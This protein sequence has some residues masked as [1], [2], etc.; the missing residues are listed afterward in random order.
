M[1]H[2]PSSDTPY[3]ATIARLWDAV[4]A[5]DAQ[6]LNALFAPDIVVR[7]PIT[8]LVCFEGADQVSDLF[9]RIFAFLNNIRMYEVVGQ[10]TATQ[11]IFWRGKVG[12]TYL[13]EANLIKMNEQGQISEMT[14]F[15]RAIPG[16]LVLLS[17]IAPSLASRHGWFRALFIRFQLVV[18]A[19]VFRAAEPMVIRLSKAGVAIKS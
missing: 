3:D 4:E 5:N 15:M 16:L 9:V 18:L 8:Q 10:S 14:V 12:Q 11:V 19:M 7:S 13:E 6:A 1:N 17:K 2:K